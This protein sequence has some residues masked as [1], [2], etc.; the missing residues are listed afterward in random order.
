MNLTLK[1][2]KNIS[3]ESCITIILNTHRTIP[4]NKKDPLLLKNLIK[5]AENR[6]LADRDKR[7]AQNLIDRLK[8]LENE[9]AHQYNI[10]SL[11]LF[12]NEEISEYIRLPIH[13]ENRVVIDN[14]FHTRDLIRGLHSESN[15]FVLVLNRQKVR[16][17]EA[18]NDKVV[19]ENSDNFPMENTSL[20]TTSPT[21]SSYS[22]RESN[23]L[24]EFFNRVDKEVN[25]V[26]RENPLPV[27]I[28]S[29]EANFHD[30]LKIAD[31]KN[32]I[33]ETF[34]T[35]TDSNANANHIVKEAWEVMREL[36][37]AS[38][39]KRKEELLKAVG[40]GN[41]MSDL[42][43]IWRALQQGRVRTLFIEQG[44]FQPGIMTENE[45]QLVAEENRRNSDVVDDVYD[46]MIEHNLRFG[47]D[48]VFLPKGELDKFNGFGAILRY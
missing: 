19:E 35:H 5:E 11:I 34:V 7:D 16:L 38:N 31:D 42:N 2:L 37:I 20:F 48:V 15:Y 32:S 28:Y 39:N 13:V 27:L 44:L 14:T 3:S 6:L 29:T 30:Y 26:R 21:E 22:S 23:L 18:Y 46:E 36:T 43:D 25:N 8:N 9:I 45:I 17:I 41:F 12:V 4:D 10:E 24:A 33:I 1:K 47:G 40:A